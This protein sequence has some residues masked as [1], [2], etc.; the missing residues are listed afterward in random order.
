MGANRIANLNATQS[1]ILADLI[2]QNT[3]TTEPNAWGIPLDALVRAQGLAAETDAARS[4]VY[5]AEV[6]FRT[7][8]QNRDALNEALLR[9]LSTIVNGVYANPENTPG[10][11]AALGL[12]PR[13]TTRHRVRPTPPTS[14]IV[15]PTT[16]RSVLLRW[17]RTLNPRDTNF[18]VEAKV[19]AGGWELAGDTKRS[20]L[21]LQGYADGGQVH[22]R[23]RASRLGFIS[24]P[25]APVHLYGEPVLRRAA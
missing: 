24:P 19:V 20:R 10:M 14:L 17:D 25:S 18:L 21:T 11:I 1:T 3:G 6:R 22:F 2:L 12:S 23:V 15:T 8:L 4:A 9:T 13:S 16:N 7:A 5:A